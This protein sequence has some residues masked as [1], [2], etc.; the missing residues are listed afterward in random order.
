MYYLLITNPIDWT[1]DKTWKSIHLK[2][3]KLTFYNPL[4][5][6]DE[7]AKRGFIG[8]FFQIGH[9][10]Y[11]S[12]KGLIFGLNE[13]TI[14]SETEIAKSITKLMLKLRYISKQINISKDSVIL[15]DTF[16]RALRSASI[17]PITLD[18]AKVQRYIHSSR[19]DH[20][21]IKIADK[22]LINGIEEKSYNEIAL[23]AFESFINLDYRKCILYSAI[24]SEVFLKHIYSDAYRKLLSNNKTNKR[25][26]VVAE[27]TSKTDKEPIFEHLIE[28]SK[29]RFEILLHELPLYIYMFTFRY[30]YPSLYEKLNILHDTRN[31]I[32]HHGQIIS[33]SKNKKKYLELNDK[34]AIESFNILK[35]LYN[36]FNDNYLDDL[37]L[38]FEEIELNKNGN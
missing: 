8:T 21:K 29:Y 13:R 26:R 1:L 30:D 25:F 4:F 15:I 6:L 31:L 3:I 27:P 7:Y 20:K 19:I 23:D 22:H 2:S 18:H 35:S 16:N 34:G 12:T 37:N 28:D 9:N 11:L 17:E 36:K 24:S 10:Y 32:V 14:L 5:F 38:E 33:N